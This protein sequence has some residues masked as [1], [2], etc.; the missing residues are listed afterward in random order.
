MH[1]LST[2]DHWACKGPEVVCAGTWAECHNEADIRVGHRLIHPDLDVRTVE[3][4]QLEDEV[5]VASTFYVPWSPQ[6]GL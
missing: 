3:G 6:H 1:P 4:L 2:A 5:P